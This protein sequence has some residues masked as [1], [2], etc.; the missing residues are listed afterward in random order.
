MKTHDAYLSGLF[1]CWG[2]YNLLN[3]AC[4]TFLDMSLSEYCILASIV[5]H[6][7]GLSVNKIASDA[8]GHLLTKDYEDQL[9]KKEFIRR[10]RDAVDRRMLAYAATNKGKKAVK[11]A[12]AMLA[13]SVM[14]N[15][16]KL[17]EDSFSQ[18]V[19]LMQQFAESVDSSADSALLLPAEALRVLGRYRRAVAHAAASFSM[20]YFQLVVLVLC[21]RDGS[22]VSSLELTKSLNVGKE[23]L[24]LSLDELEGKGFIQKDEGLSAYALTDAGQGRLEM[25]GGRIRAQLRADVADMKQQSAG[26]FDSM[27]QYVMYLFS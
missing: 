12:D 23:V 9:L 27:V 24:W 4:Y 11:R 20:S 26:A 2:L 17:N 25:L 5:E 8:K 22:G 18:L 13:M 15:Y 21:G 6:P 19:E 3:G 10:Q 16:T 14:N 7:S 1:P